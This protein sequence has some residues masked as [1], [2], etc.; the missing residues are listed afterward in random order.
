MS[1][2]TELGITNKHRT[3]S[4]YCCI[5]FT[6]QKI[7][8]WYLDHGWT[9]RCR[10]LMYLLT[11]ACVLARNFESWLD[12]TTERFPFHIL[13]SGSLCCGG[14]FQLCVPR[15]VAFREVQLSAFPA[16]R[17]LYIIQTWWCKLAHAIAK[18]SSPLGS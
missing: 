3:Q 7:L 15:L 10:S 12:K 13:I 16:F 4:S 9:Y 6:K 5:F 14:V 8:H 11:S 18:E 17:A 1:H 2:M